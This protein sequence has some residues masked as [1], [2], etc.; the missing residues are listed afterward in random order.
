M[1]KRPQRHISLYVI[2][3]CAF[4]IPLFISFYRDSL[5]YGQKQ[6]LLSDSKG[7]AFHIYNASEEDTAY[8]K[9]IDGLSEPVYED[10]TVYLSI[11]SDDEW[12]DYTRMFDYTDEITN[13]I[14]SVEG[15]QWSVINYDYYYAHGI[16]TDP[17]DI[18]EQWT[19]LIANVIII[20]IS[21][22]VIWSAYRNHIRKFSSDM[23]IILSYGATNRGI[24]KI[25][26][27]EFILIFSLSLISALVISWVVVK[28]LFVKFFETYSDNG[29]AW[30]IFHVDIVN[31][32]ICIL[33]LLVTL[34]YAVFSTMGSMEKESMWT[35]ISENKIS[36]NRSFDACRT[37]ERSLTRFWTQR[38]GREMYGCLL[39]SVPVMVVFFILMGYWSL[40]IRYES[41][42]P[43]RDII[44]ST[45]FDENLGFSD[46]DIRFVESLNGV[47]EAEWHQSIPSD[48]YLLIL[49]NGGHEHEHEHEGEHEHEHEHEHESD[50]S[51]T[52]VEFQR[53]SDIAG[54]PGKQLSKFEAFVPSHQD[55]TDFK[56]GSTISISET[57]GEEIVSD[58]IV[59]NVVGTVDDEGEEEHH[60][61]HHHAFTLF[62]SDELYDTIYSDALTTYCEIK[63]TDIDLCGDVMNALK[64]HFTRAEYMIQEFDSQIDYSHK[65]AEGTYYLLG[66]IFLAVFIFV[67]IIVTAKIKDYIEDMGDVIRTLYT[68]GASKKTISKSFMSQAFVFA[69]AAV[70]LPVIITIILLFVLSKLTGFELTASGTEIIVFIG[71]SLLISI[72]YIIPVHSTV[73][74]VL[75]S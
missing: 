39:V 49:E 35:L 38:C 70:V 6:F 18:S 4:L 26:I 20:L 31:T 5:A 21:A 68:L 52:G 27:T 30:I 3:T 34:L 17:V 14:N 2:L 61:D 1:A 62:I 19:L 72:A 56:E 12:K 8:F 44:L 64:S 43:E 67:M 57:V 41:S 46:E 28:A 48:R 74:R 60:H 53:Y 36:A 24:R 73:K 37:P 54:A 75:N 23:G 50:F 63:L 47:A 55:G 15:K 22:Y 58:S 51:I 16:S 45:R 25:F 42:V 10:G 13:V 59:F 65:A 32:L 71:I 69:A 66:Y 9:G 40:N 33:F 7:Q 11:L 29:L